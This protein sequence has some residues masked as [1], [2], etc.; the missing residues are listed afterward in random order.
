MSVKYT[1]LKSTVR[2]FGVNKIMAQPYDEL[3]KKFGT[4]K[5]PPAIP[6]LADDE[7]KISVL[8]ICGF[9]TLYIRHKNKTDYI[10]IYL[11]GG[12]SAEACKNQRKRYAAALL[13]VIRQVLSF[14]RLCYAV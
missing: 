7:M 14:G 6:R 3:K 5:K 10:G 9:P 4:G 11:A 8:K 12:G 13:S 1:I 2:M